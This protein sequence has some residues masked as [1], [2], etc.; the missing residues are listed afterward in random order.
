M[1]LSDPVSGDSQDA[2]YHLVFLNGLPGKVPAPEVLTLH[3]AH[4]AELDRQ[5]KLVLAGP[6]VGRFAGL[7][8]L[9]TESVAESRQIADEDP[10]I[11]EG[12]QSYEV[13]T[14]VQ[15]GRGNNYQPNLA[16]VTDT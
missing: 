16:Q 8:V 5:G 10:M 14:W 13:V 7:L 3:A 9:R 4:L 2:V 1:P 11:R 15:A 12:F 6:F